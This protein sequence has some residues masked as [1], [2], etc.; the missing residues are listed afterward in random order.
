MK[1]LIYTLTFLAFAILLQAQSVEFE[2]SNFPGQKDELK[3][4]RKQLDIGIEFFMQGRREFDDFRRDYVAQ[5]K[6]LP[7]GQYDYRKAGYKNFVIY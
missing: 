1:K 4:A 6:Y 3:I 7:V 2:K 5:N